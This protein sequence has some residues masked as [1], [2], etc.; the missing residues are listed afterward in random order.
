MSLQPPSKLLV[1]AINCSTNDIIEL[2]VIL[3]VVQNEALIIYVLKI[4]KTGQH[5]S[6]RR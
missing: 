5:N 2:H 1:F 6:M 3:I 4:Y